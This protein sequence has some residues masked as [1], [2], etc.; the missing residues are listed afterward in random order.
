MRITRNRIFPVVTAALL[1][2]AMTSCFKDEP[3]TAEKY[4][5]WREKNEQYLAEAALKEDSSGESYYKRIVPDWAPNT[6]VLVHWHNDRALT[7][8][9]L[10]PMSNSTVKIKYELYD[11][12]GERLSD[13]YSNNDSTYTSRPSQNI[14]GMWAAMTAMSVGD[15]VTMVIPAS[16]GYGNV[17]HG[18]IPP[19]STL[20][21]N[22]KLKSIPAYE[23]P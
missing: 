19:Y 1:G 23:I 15:S 17:M 3:T 22:V 11:I 2:L 10:S 12:D 20:V 4:Q 7:A 9:N 13:S 16:A 14:I 18:S 6:Y 21:Y 5:E 8:G